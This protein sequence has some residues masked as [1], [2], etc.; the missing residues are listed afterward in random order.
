M[1]FERLKHH[2]GHKIVCVG[3]GDPNDPVEVSIECETCCEVLY[4]V[5]DEEEDDVGI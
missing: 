1:E 4:S 2:R 3:Y 5:N